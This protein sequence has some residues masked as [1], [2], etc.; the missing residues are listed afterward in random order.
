M[1]LCSLWLCGIS[2]LQTF[3]FHREVTNKLE[4]CQLGRG[5]LLAR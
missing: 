2:R 4:T 1:T 5:G 3:D